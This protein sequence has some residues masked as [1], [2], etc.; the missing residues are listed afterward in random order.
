MKKL[1]AVLFAISAIFFNA[2][3]SFAEPT[4][5]EIKNAFDI[6][7]DAF[8]DCIMLS[9]FGKA[10]KEVTGEGLNMQFAKLDLTTM[11]IKGLGTYTLLSGKIV[12]KNKNDIYADLVLTGGSVKNISWVVKNF[13]VKRKDHTAEV[14][15]DGKELTF[16]VK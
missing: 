10:P 1:I 5:T 11:K 4:E 16:A 9:A 12:V 6:T 8:G 2:G 7:F 13:D 14:N 3:N 15:A